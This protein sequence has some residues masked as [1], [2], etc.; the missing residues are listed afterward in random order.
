VLSFL[1]RANGRVHVAGDAD[2]RIAEANMRAENAVALWEMAIASGKDLQ[3]Q[4]DE[5][6]SWVAGL[7]KLSREEINT[8]VAA[9]LHTS[10]ANKSA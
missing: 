10:A 9:R 4:V 3:G 5:L 1:D 6:A 2:E 8:V 7:T